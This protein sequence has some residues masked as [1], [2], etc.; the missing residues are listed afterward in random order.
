MSTLTVTGLE[1]L[2]DGIGLRTPVPYFAAA[3][4]LTKPLDIG[5]AYFADILSSLVECDPVTAFNSIQS[6]NNID[7]GYDLA[8]VLPKLSHDD[9]P[10]DLGFDLMQRVRAC[11][12]TPHILIRRASA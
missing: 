8:A 2:L 3:D 5:R 11:P 1:T 7:N 9:D 10:E 6:P 4:V 12:F